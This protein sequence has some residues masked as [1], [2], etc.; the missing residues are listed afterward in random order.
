MD[1]GFRKISSSDLDEHIKPI[2]EQLLLAQV[3]NREYG[4]CMRVGDLSTKLM[5]E[6]AA[7]MTATIGEQA[8]V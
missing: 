7:S 1:N 6:V 8:Q 2:V 5:L 4:H 3:L